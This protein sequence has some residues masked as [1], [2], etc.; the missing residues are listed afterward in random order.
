MSCLNLQY[1]YICD[2]RTSVVELYGT[3]SIVMVRETQGV[4]LCGATGA[5]M[6]TGKQTMMEYSL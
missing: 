3:M 2:Y 5:L 6:L 4:V 1:M